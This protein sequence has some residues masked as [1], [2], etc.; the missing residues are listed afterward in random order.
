MTR[1]LILLFSKSC[2]RTRVIPKTSCDVLLLRLLLLRGTLLP[3][4]SVSFVFSFLL[5]Q[6]FNY[7]SHSRLLP[8]THRLLLNLSCKKGNWNWNWLSSAIQCDLSSWES[9]SQDYTLIACEGGSSVVS[10]RE[11]VLSLKTLVLSLRKEHFVLLEDELLL[12][13][14]RLRRKQNSETQ[15]W[16][17]AFLSIGKNVSMSLGI[18]DVFCTLLLPIKYMINIRRCSTRKHARCTRWW[19]RIRFQSQHKQ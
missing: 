19:G 12:E 17:D 18:H 10:S 5:L 16:Q 3:F 6:Y 2:L 7:S 11:K 14:T 8:L 15:A 9:Q 1:L 4:N 13:V